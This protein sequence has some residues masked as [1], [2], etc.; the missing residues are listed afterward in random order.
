MFL[1]KVFA[2]A[3]SPSDAPSVLDVTAAIYSQSLLTSMER[4]NSRQLAEVASFDPYHFP[5]L[6]RRGAWDAD[7]LRAEQPGVVLGGLSEEDVALAIDETGFIKQGKKSLG[8]KRQYCGA[9]DKIDN[10]QIG[11][12]LS[13][14][15]A[16][17]YALMDRALYLPEI[18][19][20]MQ[21]VA[22]RPACPQRW[23]SLPSPPWRTAFVVVALVFQLGSMCG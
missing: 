6:L 11:V 7:A 1:K 16:V 3:S 19:P 21:S 20:Q 8:V 5:H 22:G 17:G 18:G 10:C 15:T 4:K 2:K 13:W 9:S 12:F 14:Q 23:S